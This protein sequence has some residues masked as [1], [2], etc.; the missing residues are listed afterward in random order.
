PGLT[1]AQQTTTWDGQ[2]GLFRSTFA[3]FF[4]RVV[5]FQS[6]KGWGGFLGWHSTLGSVGLYSREAWLS[7]FGVTVFGLGVINLLPIPTLN[8]G[9]LFLL[10]LE[11]TL[12]KHY[13]SI[14]VKAAYVGFAIVLIG[15]MRVLIAD[16]FWLNLKP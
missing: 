5:S 8:G 3:E 6:L 14:Q 13:E 15:L 11:P 12:G 16:Y 2:W 4:L 1:V 7:C 9:H 10:L